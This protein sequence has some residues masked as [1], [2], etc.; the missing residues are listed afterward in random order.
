MRSTS[1]VAGKK[2][3]N[4]ASLR[5]RERKIS[6]G[7]RMAETSPSSGV[8]E[9]ALSDASWRQDMIILR[10]AAE[11][12]ARRQSQDA[13]SR[14]VSDRGV[15]EMAD[16]LEDQSSV[17]RKWAARKLYEL[18][19]DLAATLVNEALLDGSAEQR[20]NIGKALAESGLLFEAIDDLMAKNHER[21]YGAFSLLL[22]VAKAGVV[23]P[24]ITVIEKHPSID[25]RL[26][27]IRLLA[28]SR[29]TQV[30]TALQGFVNQGTLAPE[31]R[32]ETLNAIRQIT[33]N[34]A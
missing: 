2:S 30:A 5:S 4:Q 10:K 22:L 24:L 28:S 18:N 13:L 1:A 26:A 16:L 7:L 17:T 12:R 3:K 6:D 29:D 31:L 32:S 15:R 21:C 19:E 27:V 8:P 23:Q 14:G 34:P 25:L 33:N 11:D 20:R 9:S